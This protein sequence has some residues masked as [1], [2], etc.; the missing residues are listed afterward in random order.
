MRHVAIIGCGYVGT[1]A[2]SIWSKRGV[3]VTATTRDPKRLDHLTKVAQKGLLIK[4]NDEAEYAQLLAN[5]DTLLISVAADSSNHYESA[6]LHTAQILRHLAAERDQPKRLIYT[7]STY[8]YG[9]HQGRWVDEESALHDRTEQGR[10]LIE[11]EETYESLVELGWHVTIFRFAEIYGP[12]RE[13][14][15]RLKELGNR[16]LPGTGEQYTNMVHRDDCAAAIDFASRH[17]L[18]GIINLADDDHPTRKELFEAVAMK[19]HLPIPQ[20]DDSVPGLRTANKRV[21]NHKIKAQGFVF[22][23][24]QRLLI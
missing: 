8:V 21:S 13:L 16:D 12:G 7:S 17:N 4:G 3:H 19:H 11:A 20:W 1:E 18:L 14:S 6:Y 9:D 15:K 10:I 23:H 5:H 2:A 22:R 24:P